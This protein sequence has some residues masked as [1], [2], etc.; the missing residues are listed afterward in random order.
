MIV[1]TT[2]EPRRGPG[3]RIEG[4]KKRFGRR[5]ALRGVD[6]SIDSGEFCTIF[7]PNGAGKTTLV[8]CLATL[9]RPSGGRIR[10][11]GQELRQASA[12][13][14]R[15]LGVVSHASFLHPPLTARENL[16][17]YGSM[18]GVADPGRR[19]EEVADAVGIG[20]RL[21]D[22]VRTFSRG[23]LQRCAIARALV[24]DPDLLLFDEPF[25]GLDPVAADSLRDL[26][27]DA[28]RDGTTVVMT[29]HDLERGRKLADRIVVLDRGR[30]ALDSP[31]AEISAT[32]LARR[33]RESTK[34][35]RP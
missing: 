28:R 14:R 4:L 31:S 18:F 15:R 23:L 11:D 30:V 22:P 13:I 5:A 25:A 29:S 3:I 9:S 17:F 32:D 1:P 21:D 7:G 2:E 26:L 20:S 35:R 24:H 19:A 27:T 34:G 8:R 12:G 33:Y 16:S 10:I 6:L